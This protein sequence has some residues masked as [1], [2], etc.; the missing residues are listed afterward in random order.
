MTTIQKLRTRAVIRRVAKRQ[1]IS[2][3]QC[4]A[5]MIEAIQAAWTT[6]DPQ[7]KAYQ[8][9]LV[10]EGRVPTPEELIFLISSKLPKD[11]T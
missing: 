7:V 1:G 4:R 3:T 9:G 2:T 6:T 8:I 10:G 11:F 5:D